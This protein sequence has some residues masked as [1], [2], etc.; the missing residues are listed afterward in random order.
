MLP[1]AGFTCC[2]STHWP[3][4]PSHTWR[5]ATAQVVEAKEA[6][7]AGIIGII[8][9]VNGRGTPV[10]SSFAA[11]LGLDAPVEVVNLQE[12]ELMA[13]S[14]VVFYGINLGVGLSIAVP[15]FASQMAH[16]LLGQLPFGAISLVGVR[17]FDEAT[18]ARNSGADALLVKREMVE[19][20]QQQGMDV[21]ALISRLQYA[22]GGDD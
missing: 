2:V 7:A 12:V 16:G 21:Q 19:V 13:R 1:K 14:G 5:A 17:T 11:A 15:G 3:H 9:Q 4:A 8:H 18:R 22:V 10:M 20:C 6:G